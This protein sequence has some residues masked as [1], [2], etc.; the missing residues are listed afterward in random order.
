MKTFIRKYRNPILLHFVILI[1]G[2]TGILGK[3]ISID[4]NF[5]VLY[6]MS[7][8]FVSLLSFFMITRRSLRE[9]GANMLRYLLTGFIIAAHWAFFF[10]SLKVSTVS[11]TLT[12]L[13]S[14]SLFVAFIEPLLFKRKIDVLEVVFS[15]IVILGLFMIFSFETDYA[16]GILYALISA[17]CAALFGTLNGLFIRRGS[18]FRISIYEMLGGMIGIALYSFLNGSLLNLPFPDL[19]DWFFLLILGIVCTAFAFVVSVEVMKTLTP[20][21]VSISI[22]M[23]PI[24]AIILAL[25]FFGNEELMSPGFYAG[26]VLI[27]LT[28]MSNG[29]YKSPRGKRL[30]N[31][32][33]KRYFSKYST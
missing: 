11:V 3:I 8:A 26:A 21:T 31:A 2:F 20:F 19:N 23:E 4:S 32:L 28:V 15:S 17:F 30:I 25:L 16:L 24:Y 13:A 18:A 29:I 6:R 22:N 10:E 5:I 9:E 14:T 7:I 12:C 27:F 1:W 33:S